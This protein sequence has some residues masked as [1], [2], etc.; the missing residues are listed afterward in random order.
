[1]L[2]DI[3]FMLYGLKAEIISFLRRFP[4]LFWGAKNLDKVIIVSDILFYL[5]NLA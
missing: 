2:Y 3:R 4:L 5:S 1:M